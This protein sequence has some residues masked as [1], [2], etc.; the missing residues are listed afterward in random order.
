MKNQRILVSITL[1][2]GMVFSIQAADSV[3]TPIPP[4]GMTALY[5][6]LTLDQ[7]V[8]TATHTPKGL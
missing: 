6:S 2:V 4:K 7:V 1:S 5:D 8:V 3:N